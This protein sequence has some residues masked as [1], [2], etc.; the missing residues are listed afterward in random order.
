MSFEWDGR[1]SADLSLAEASG[2][3]YGVV[4]GVVTANQDPA[5]LG[6]V[7][8]KFPWLSDSDESAWAR[9]A[10]FMAGKERG[11]FYLPEVDD[12]VVVAF[13]HG[14]PNYPYVLGAL[15]NGQDTPP[16]ANADGKNNKRL[17]KSRS[18]LTILLDD[19]AGG[20]KIQISD[21]D[22]QNMLVVD[23]ANKKISLT[24]S[25]DI[26]IKAA[27]G[28]VTIEAQ[29]LKLN[30]TGPAEVKASGTLNIEGQTVNIKGQPM[31]NIN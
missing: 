25:G 5:K 28:Q 20:E 15:W 23:V 22:G 7:K 27:Q 24:S 13:E 11:A 1:Q 9:L 17:L 3:I 12:E 18:G 4:V 30:S 14:D 21:K 26:E 10:T 31:V 2:R 8:V 19:T 6:R 16:E 29:Q